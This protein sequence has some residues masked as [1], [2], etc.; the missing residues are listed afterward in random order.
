MAYFNQFVNCKGKNEMQCISLVLNDNKEL[1]EGKKFNVIELCGESSLPLIAL[2][3]DFS[4]TNNVLDIFKTLFFIIGAGKI[5]TPYGDIDTSKGVLFRERDFQHFD[6]IIP[7]IPEMLEE[8]DGE[9]LSAYNNFSLL[10]FAMGNSGKD[11]IYGKYLDNFYTGIDYEKMSTIRGKTNIKSITFKGLNDQGVMELDFCNAESTKTFQI[12]RFIAAHF[13]G[14]Y[15]PELSL[16][17]DMKIEDVESV[18]NT[19]MDNKSI[20][21]AED[22][23][24]IK[25]EFGII[26]KY[27]DLTIPVISLN[28]KHIKQMISMLERQKDKSHEQFQGLNI[29]KKQENKQPS[30][31]INKIFSNLRRGLK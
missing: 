14:V 11:S 23:G 10:Y 6:T 12:T 17:N 26:V 16:P 8:K 31:L 22:I 18:I 24:K 19:L 21:F 4:I 13:G 15:V 25:F 7:I 3:P 2:E 9:K 5:L 29:P 28:K 1:I 30:G 20:Y 27:K